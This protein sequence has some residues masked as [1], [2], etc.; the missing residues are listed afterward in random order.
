MRNIV[1]WFNRLRGATITWYRDPKK[2]TEQELTNKAVGID[3]PERL[4]DEHLLRQ[5]VTHRI[6][7]IEDEWGRRVIVIERTA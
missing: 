3:P 6:I 5:G 1:V 4:S 2:P 7:G